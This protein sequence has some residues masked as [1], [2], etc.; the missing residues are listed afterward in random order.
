[1]SQPSSI[2]KT[3]KTPK[4]VEEF[5]QGDCNMIS[6]EEAFSDGMKI[7]DVRTAE[8][9]QDGSIPDSLSFPLFDQME[10]A[11]IGTLYKQI[12]QQSAIDCG[13]KIVEAKLNQFVSSFDSLKS[14][15]VVIYCAR[16]GMRS[17]SVVRLLSDHGFNVCQMAGGYKAYRQYVLKQLE[18]EAPPFIVLHGQTGVGK[19]LVLQKLPDYLD[20]E[21][22]AQHRSSLFGAIHKKPRTQK[23][24]EGLLVSKLEKLPR[25][26]RV[27]IEGESRKVGKVFIPDSIADGMKKGKLILLTA[28]IETRIQRIVEEYQV[29]SEKSILE[30]EQILNSLKVALGKV[31]VDQLLKWLMQDKIDE[32]VRLLLEDYYDPRYLH[33]M[34]NYVFEMELSAEDL[35]QTVEELIQFRQQSN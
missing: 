6:V 29:V 34:K 15:P 35:E 5:L 31:K 18:K 16:G 13:T 3:L 27:F 30:I 9:Y 22:L 25:N 8:E 28:S 7:V 11:E 32:I 14:D 21:G 4:R 24:F 10:R 23:N 19:T 2:S 33:A 12:G 26:R 1:M 17:A 20:L